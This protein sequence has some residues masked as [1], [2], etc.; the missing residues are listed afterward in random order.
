MSDVFMRIMLSAVGGA[1]VTSVMQSVAS[2]ISG[3]GGLVGALGAVGLAAGAAAIG[4]G[5]TAVQAAGSFQQAIKNLES[6]AG[7]AASQVD[8]VTSA[9]MKMGP[10]VGKGPTELA[11]A[12][13]PV[14]SGLSSMTNESAK[15]QV[16]LA[17]LNDAAKSVA[18]TQTDTNTVTKAA[19][20]AFNAFNLQTDDAA[21]NVSRMHNLFDVMNATVTAGNMQWSNYAVKVG[22]LASKASQSHV[23]FT[24]ANSALAVFTNT[25]ESVQL[26]GT[27]LGALFLKMGN[28]ADTLQKHA[29]KLHITFDAAKF[30]SLDLAD[31]IKYL[32]DITGNDPGKIKA[33]LGNQTLAVTF[34]KLSDHAND[35]TTTL[36]SLDHS[37]GAT[38]QAFETASSGF[39]FSMQKL[40]AAG[41][42]LL[43]TIGSGLLPILTNLANAVLPV[44]SGF[45]Q[46]LA[47]GQAMSALQP[48]FAYLAPLVG[49]L[50]A[51]FGHLGS[52][53]APLLAHLGQ[54]IIHSG[55]LQGMVIGLIVGIGL[56]IQGF[57]WLVNGLTNVI[58][59]FTTS[60]SN[61]KWLWD[62]LTGIGAFL[63]SIFKPVWDQLVSTWKSQ[64]LP[65]LQ[66]LM[67]VFQQLWTSLQG[68]MP[69]LQ[70]L[71]IL[72]GGILVVVFGLLIS[73]I[74]GLLG[75]IA[76]TLPGIIQIFGGI[77]QF[78]SGALQVIIG[79]TALFIDLF[80]G[81]W[82]KLGA[83]LGIIWRGV[84]AMFSGLWNVI[85]GIFSAAIGLVV[86]FV[87]T[88]SSTIIKFFTTLWNDLVGHSIIPDMINGIVD[89]FMQL[90]GRAM[91]AIASLPGQM[92][93]L[94]GNLANQ[95]FQWGA[96]IIKNL[97]SSIIGGIGSDLSGAMNS[98]SQFIS[99]HLPH[100]PAKLGPLQD[101]ARQGSLITQQIGQGIQAGLPQLQTSLGLTLQPIASTLSGGGTPP[102]GEYTARPQAGTTIIFSPNITLQGLDEE[103]LE[104]ASR[105][106]QQ[107][108]GNHVRAQYGNV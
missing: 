102:T 101:L 98:V 9:L 74:A 45:A 100:S 46:W 64:L 104:K 16:A 97:A 11:T 106:L 40:Q 2:S 73:I 12:L 62:I 43:I 6:H 65:A 86:G 61:A 52:V 95:A 18:G 49:Q 81:K 76:G 41:Q 78:I 39:N 107:E 60:G 8:T 59:F 83:D 29:E 34:Q 70:G 25:G 56:L 15:T 67:P 13:Y 88:F 92:I 22:D 37:Q 99:D 31:K 1:G 68:L 80:T 84:V 108:L 90:P 91:S 24:E 19:T 7:L 38:A 42:T 105:W 72:V 5:V 79:V 66:Q 14:L 47:S 58:V 96:N 69:V 94:F 50:G 23:S 44:I 17:E 35:Y 87:S 4:L 21:T 89:W 93:G 71:G 82:G 20:A 77:V 85:V 30:K 55:I 53:L 36:H 57:T 48:I 27:H 10:E 103:S 51:A 63:V 32:D 26:A 3:S 28:D 54:I 33:I 75:A